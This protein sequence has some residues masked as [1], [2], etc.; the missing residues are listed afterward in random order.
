M[1]V[2][3]VFLF[4]LYV[5]HRWVSVHWY[6]FKDTRDPHRSGSLSRAEQTGGFNPE[7]VHFGFNFTNSELIDW[8]DLLGQVSK[9]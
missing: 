6:T 8:A 1:A 4:I 2:L 5:I 3:C 9:V 7:A